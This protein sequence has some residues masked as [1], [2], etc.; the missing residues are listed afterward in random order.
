MTKEEVKKLHGSDPVDNEDDTYMSYVYSLGPEEY[1]HEFLLDYAFDSES[2]KAWQVSW[3]I[4]V[5]DVETG[6]TLYNDIVGNFEAKY[7]KGKDVGDKNWQEMEW[8][9]VQIN[10]QKTDITVQR[11]VNS[12]AGYLLMYFEESYE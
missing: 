6:K 11:M 5:P 2:G 9:G 1:D 10:G 4:S 12:E 8:K 7:G 3:D